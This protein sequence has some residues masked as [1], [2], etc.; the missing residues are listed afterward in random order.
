MAKSG[1]D[2]AKPGRSSSQT[3][4]P[5]DDALYHE[6]GKI[7]KRPHPLDPQTL[8]GREHLLGSPAVLRRGGANA[9][10]EHLAQ[11]ASEV[12]KESIANIA[13]EKSRR[14]AEAVFAVNKHYIGKLIYERQ[15]VLAAHH[16]ISENEYADCRPGVI[17]KLIWQLQNPGQAGVRPP[18]VDS[19]PV[20]ALYV[21]QPASYFYYAT[22]AIALIE[23]ELPE[24]EH[25]PSSRDPYPSLYESHVT[26]LLK[27]HQ[28]LHAPVELYE[29]T[30]TLLSALLEQ[31]VALGPFHDILYLAY[32]Y[33]TPPSLSF[34][35][36]HSYDVE[37]DEKLRTAWYAWYRSQRNSTG[38]SPL[39]VISQK[40]A[41]FRNSLPNV[42]KLDPNYP[43]PEMDVA[44]TIGAGL[45]AA[46]LPYIGELRGRSGR[47][48]YAT[49]S[50][51]SNWYKRML[52]RLPEAV[53]KDLRDL[54]K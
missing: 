7:G 1:R 41:T 54:A 14:I 25:A 46:V 23:S 31:I 20:R 51:R 34:R 52:R 32:A 17:Q 43:N 37:I 4:A 36:D 9:T 53:N 13:D 50:A 40:V 28:F 22:I 27:A 47:R 10:E 2:T 44:E 12:L 5:D 26:F 15:A 38:E 8:L 48:L 35:L 49:E 3:L 30:E 39:R 42:V 6:L 29:H 18:A 19:F 33:S 45:F 21:C 11:C 24:L 16:Y